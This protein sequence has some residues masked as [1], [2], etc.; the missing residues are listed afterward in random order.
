[1]GRARYKN[2]VAS[3]AADIRRGRIAPGTRLP[4]HRDL[5]AEHGLA[6]A[7]ASRVYAELTDMGLVRGETGRGTYVRD[8]RLPP[9]HGIDQ[10]DVADGAIDLNFNYSVLPGQSE[11]LR[12]SLRGL[13]SRGDLES[14]L[15]Y[16]PHGGRMDE[17][18]VVARHLRRSGVTVAAEQVLIVD[19]AQHG[20]ATVAMAMLKPGDVVAVDALTYPGFKVLAETLQLELVPIPDAGD[21][22]DLDALSRV[23]KRRRIRAMYTMP[24]LHNPLGWVTPQRS[25][26]QLVKIIREHGL[27]VIED[28][29]Y[30]FLIEQPPAPLAALAPESTFYVSGLSKS[31]STGL[32]F[33]YVVAPRAHI[34]AME[35][36]IRATTWSTPAIVTA[37]ATGWIEDGTVAHL[38]REKRLDAQ[39][40]QSLARR[41][42]DE[43]PLIGHPNSYFVWLPLADGLRADQLAARLNQSNIAVSTAE[44][45][46]TVKSPPHALRIALGSVSSDVLHQSLQTVKRFL[47]QAI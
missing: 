20:L 12:K 11:L 7:T 35:R 9:G 23:C 14:L 4:T 13:A 24:T 37:L 3:L 10:M 40:R 45:F 31:V 26:L 25:R 30:A 18:A 27:L 43:F 36:I 22:P 33:G 29:A 34:A 39:H 2:V 28:A 5:A 21:G 41:V 1:V 15:R 8:I 42:L 17:R 44:P 19:G 6:V 32:R 16:Q 47:Q 38:E 46:S